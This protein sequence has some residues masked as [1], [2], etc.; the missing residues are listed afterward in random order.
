[1]LN[2]QAH[3]KV[4]VDV[5]A[6]DSSG[7]LLQLQAQIAASSAALQRRTHYDDVPLQLS[8]TIGPV[9]LSK[10]PVTVGGEGRLARKLRG[11]LQGTVQG[12]GSLQA[13]VLSVHAT[14]THLAAG[15]VELGK[16]EMQIDYRGGKTTVVVELDSQNGGT[17]RLDGTV[18]LDLSYP[19]IRR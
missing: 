19:A 6:R 14:N 2:V 16:S 7:P 13:R 10:L 3:Q 15:D 8:G 1:T 9:D 18:T 17:L 5:G 4:V 12:Q 11:T